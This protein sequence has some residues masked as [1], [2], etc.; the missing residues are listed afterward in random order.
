MGAKSKIGD[1]PFFPHDTFTWAKL[2]EAN[3]RDIREELD[4]LL[5]HREHLPN[6]QDLSTEQREL[7]TDDNW[8]TY[9]FTGYGISFEG[10]RTRCPR[11]ATL[12]DQVPG[13][14]TAFFSVLGPGK[15]LPEHRGLRLTNYAA[16]SPGA[17]KPPGMGAVA[18]DDPDGGARQRAHPH[19]GRRSAGRSCRLPTDSRPLPPLAR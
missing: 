17:A 11:T 1:T 4:D 13:L 5:S 15:R 16:E 14:S 19:P 9:F 10:N 7:S 12:L 3:W 18:T 8:K 6:F 2:L